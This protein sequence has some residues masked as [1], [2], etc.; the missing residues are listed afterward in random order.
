[1]PKATKSGKL[2]ATPRPKTDADLLF[3]FMHGIEE[4]N[5]T[6]VAMQSPNFVVFRVKGHSASKDT[7]R[8]LVLPVAAS[9][10]LPNTF[11]FARVIGT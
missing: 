5:H 2:V 1:M 8:G 9:M 10:F 4:K 6:V 7:P 3:D 11:S